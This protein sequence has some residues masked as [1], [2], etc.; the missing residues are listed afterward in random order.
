MISKYIRNI[1]EIKIVITKENKERIL[2]LIDQLVE[3]EAEGTT[4]KPTTEASRTSLEAYQSESFLKRLSFSEDVKF[5]TLDITQRDFGAWGMFN[6]F[7]PGKA[8]LRVLANLAKRNGGGPIRFPEMI[9]EC[10][11]YFSKSGLYKYRGFPKKTS[12]SARGRLSAHLITPYHE[13]GL[14]R[15]EGEGKDRFVMITKEGLSF[16]MLRNPLLDG[17]C[18]DKHLSEEERKWL[19]NHL[20]RI[21]DLGYKEFS[22]LRKLTRFL[23]SSER[24]F[25]DIADWF[26]SNEDFVNWVKTGSRYEHDPKAFSRQLE[27]VATTYTSGKIA[28][29]RELGIISNS[30]AT[31]KVLSDLEEGSENGEDES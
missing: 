16:A 20:R 22:V 30:R 2:K 1:M 5:A 29:L 4:I 14:M 11:M 6:S 3:C 17:G 25:R 26:K 15:I 31:Y 13:M 28:L 24:K 10:M 27:N 23:S 19:L 21:D 8:S 12:E 9:D 7:V 18:K